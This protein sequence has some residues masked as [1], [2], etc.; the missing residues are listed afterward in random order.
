MRRVTF[1]EDV[2]ES[3]VV[4]I[5]THNYGAAGNKVTEG[6]CEE[7]VGG[8]EAK[9]VDEA[10]VFSDLEMEKAEAL[11]QMNIDEKE[12][13]ESEKLCVNL[14]LN[15]A[16]CKEDIDQSE[17]ENETN[18][19]LEKEA[20]MAI[21]EQSVELERY[22]AAGSKQKSGMRKVLEKFPFLK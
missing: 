22:E 19:D 11:M 7:E 13:V 10:L 14:D 5:D 3:E 17:I 20:M 4:E 16:K 15:D 21:K 1:Q 12:V 9:H 18:V 6:W 8:I 2:E